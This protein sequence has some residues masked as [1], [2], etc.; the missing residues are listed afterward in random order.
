MLGARRTAALQALR[1]C[2]RP[3]SVKAVVRVTLWFALGLHQ[4]RSPFSYSGARD[5]VL[6][7]YSQVQWDQHEVQSNLPSF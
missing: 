4:Q 7:A 1:G 2:A 3:V 5:A 6:T